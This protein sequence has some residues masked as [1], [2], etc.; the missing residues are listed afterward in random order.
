MNNCELPVQSTELCSLFR[1]FNVVAAAA[2]TT[3]PR[4]RQHPAT[5]SSCS[6]CTTNTPHT[7]TFKPLCSNGNFICFKNKKFKRI[8]IKQICGPKAGRYH[9]HPSPVQHIKRILKNKGCSVDSLRVKGH[10]S[11]QPAGPCTVLDLHRSTR[12]G[13]GRTAR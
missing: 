13:G 10:Q 6:T 2:T 3:P 11:L 5:T 1:F 8:I 4:E 9:A 12:G 7:H